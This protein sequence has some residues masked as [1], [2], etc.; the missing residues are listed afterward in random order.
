M[1]RYS[2]KYINAL[3]ILSERNVHICRSTGSKLEIITK[4]AQNISPA[5]IYIYCVV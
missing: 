5:R 3:G 2:A 1:G 4:L